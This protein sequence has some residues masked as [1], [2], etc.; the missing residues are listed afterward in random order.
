[1][2]AL[3]KVSIVVPVYNGSDYLSQAIDSALAQTYPN[4]EVLVVNDGSNDGGRTED[5]VKSYG[6]QIRYVEKPNGG[7]ASALN[8]GIREMKGVYFSW[9]S[10]DDLYLPDKVQVQMGYALTSDHLAVYYSDFETIDD[11]GRSLSVVAVPFRK[12][13]ALRASL[14]QSA[15]LHGGTILIPRQAFDEVG[16]FDESLR[17]TQDYDLWFR[18]A[19]RFPFEHIPK[20][21]VRGRLHPNQGTRKLKGHVVREVNNLYR[22]Y[23]TTLTAEEI[24]AYWPTGTFSYFMA[25]SMSMAMRNYRRA[26]A[27]ALLMAFRHLYA[28]SIGQFWHG[29]SGSGRAA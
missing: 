28:G 22:R 10:H 9:L 25:T 11:K 4:I 14:M 29:R 20:V 21:L 26:A 18:M 23:L 15:N 13:A 27:F 8:A 12:P 3:P 17:T 7:V 19:A 2:T 16:V 1:M 24:A 5:I 6:S